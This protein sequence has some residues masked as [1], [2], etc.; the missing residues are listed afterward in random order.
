MPGSS[1]HILDSFSLGPHHFSDYNTG[2][3]PD[4][5]VLTTPQIPPHTR[6]A[7]GTKLYQQDRA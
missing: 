7:P 4:H 5:I 1:R 6:T 3:V 2:P